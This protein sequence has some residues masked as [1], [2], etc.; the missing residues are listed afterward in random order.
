ML[1]T[2]VRYA[3]C[4]C[5]CVCLSAATTSVARA[6]NIQSVGWDRN[7]VE[8]KAMSDPEAMSAWCIGRFRMVLPESLKL[9]GRSQSIYGVD[10]RTLPTGSKGAEMLWAEQLARIRAL[11]PPEG[12]QTAVIRRFDLLSNTPAVWYLDSKVFSRSRRLEAMKTETDHVLLLGSVTDRG[13]EEQLEAL[14]KIVVKNYVPN[15]DRGFCVGHG[16]ITSVPG[17]IEESRASFLHAVLPEFDLRFETGTVRESSTEHPLSEIEAVQ[18]EVSRNGGQ[19]KV[20]KRNARIVA[21]LEGEEGLISLMEATN[22]VP[23]LFYSWHF[24]GVATR[25]DRPQITIK[26]SAKA[27]HDSELGVVWE[28][29]LASVK[30]VPMALR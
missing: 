3:L 30:A 13:R 6:E 20:L 9:T 1:R 4:A 11:Q 23:T 28:R 10:V 12:A 15:V 24:P 22:A 29:L 2:S 14:M 27:I 16:S 18:K 25:S 8:V 21:D 5:T 7:L 19:L 26:A 17:E